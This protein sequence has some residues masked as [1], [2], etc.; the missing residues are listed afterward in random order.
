MVAE[1]AARDGGR[2]P[3]DGGA[4]GIGGVH[5][6]AAGEPYRLRSEVGED[7]PHFNGGELIGVTDQNQPRVGTAAPG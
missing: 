2:R 1:V 6:V 3:K 5:A 4:G 7:V